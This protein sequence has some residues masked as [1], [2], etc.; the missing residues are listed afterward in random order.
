V[1]KENSNE[2]KAPTETPMSAR[3]NFSYELISSFRSTTQGNREWLSVMGPTRNLRPKPLSAAERKRKSRAAKSEEAREQERF[4]DRQRKATEAA[5]ALNRASMHRQREFSVFRE[6]SARDYERAQ[7][8][9][10]K[11][12]LRENQTAET[13]D[14]GRAHNRAS[15]AK[16][17]ARSRTQDKSVEAS[18]KSSEVLVGKHQVLDLKSMNDEIDE[19]GHVD[20]HD[21]ANQVGKDT[22]SICIANGKAI[23]PPFPPTVE[24]LSR[25]SGTDAD[26]PELKGERPLNLLGLKLPSSKWKL[27]KFTDPNYPTL[28]DQ[29][30]L[31]ET[32]MLNGFPAS[33]K[34]CRIM[35]NSQ[36]IKFGVFYEVFD[37]APSTYN[38]MEELQTMID[39]F[40]SAQFCPGITE[41]VISSLQR[42]SPSL[43]AHCL[44]L[45]RDIEGCWRSDACS[46]LLFETASSVCLNCNKLQE[47]FMS[48]HPNQPKNKKLK[49]TGMFSLKINNRYLYRE[50]KMLKLRTMKRKIVQLEACAR[51]STRSIKVSVTFCLLLPT[52]CT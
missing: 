14:R 9:Q 4:R 21:G 42:V 3:E 48:K 5:R 22:T 10:R 49:S 28:K 24:D 51:N 25:L 41:D 36:H 27:S 29:W 45:K 43:T 35:T 18:L 47:S 15:M 26:S 44:M 8:R 33:R 30:D 40:E 12:T 38:S 2:I 16:Q 23:L 37:E 20:Q 13:R 17:R 32:Y 1:K 39:R 6:F 31:H 52:R 46:R 7:D 19:V 11:T 50:S 34:M